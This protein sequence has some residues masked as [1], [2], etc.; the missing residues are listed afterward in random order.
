LRFLLDLRLADLA[1]PP[2]PFDSCTSWSPR[3]ATMP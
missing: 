3:Q 2:N 1:W